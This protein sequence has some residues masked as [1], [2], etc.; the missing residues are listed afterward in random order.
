[1]PPEQRPLACATSC[2]R[3]HG[4]VAASTRFPHGTDSVAVRRAAHGTRSLRHPPLQIA[5]LF[6][7]PAVRP[8]LLSGAAAPNHRSAKTPTVRSSTRRVLADTLNTPCSVCGT[9][10]VHHMRLSFIVGG[11]GGGVCEVHLQRVA[12]PRGRS[13]T[14]LPLNHHLRKRRR[15]AAALHKPQTNAATRGA[16]SERCT[17]TPIPT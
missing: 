3:L 11:R 7:P 2:A 10:A 5:A 14:R 1:M 17:L 6:R 9:S 12:G 15:S 4:V 13:D 16:P 8:G